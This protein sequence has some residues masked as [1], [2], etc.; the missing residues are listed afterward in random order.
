MQVKFAL[1]GAMLAP[2]LLLTGCGMNPT[3]SI[4]SNAMSAAVSGRA[5]GGQN[6]VVGATI[7]VVA[8]GTSGYGSTGSILAST[9]T[10]SLGNFSFAPGA[11][12]CPQAD[13]PVY[14]TGVGGDS[15][16]GVNP[17]AVLAAGL[18]TCTNAKSSF[19][20]INEV[21]TAA[22]AFSLSHFFSPTI[23]GSNAANDWFGGPSI[24]VGGAT[25]YSKG[26]TMG[27]S[28][29]IPA[30]VSNAV[31]APN[32]PS[33]G[34]VVEAAKIN[35]IANSLAACVNSGG[36]TSTSDTS[37]PCGML[38][39]YTTPPGSSTRPSD[40]LQAAVQM[41]LFPYQNVSQI[42]NLVTP[43]APFSGLSS[44]PS[45]W[46]I[47]VSY[48]TASLGL[49][50]DTGTISTLDIDQDGKVWVPSNAAGSAG[51]AYFDPA[52]RTFNG[53]FNTTGL[54]HPQQVA[55]DGNS[56][57]WYN[58]S[59][60]TA[61]SGYL[62]TSPAST[63][64]LTMANTISDSVTIGDDNRIN[65]GIDN[66][67]VYGVANVSVD[68]SS[69]T[70]ESSVSFPYPV[71]SM[72]GDAVG[73]E[74]VTV[75]DFIIRQMQSWYVDP[76]GLTT[77]VVNTGA[78]SGQVLFTGNDFVSVHGHSTRVGSLYDGLCIY[79]QKTCYPFANTLNN[80]PT[81]IAIDGAANLWVTEGGDSAILHIPVTNPSAGNAT[82][83]LNTSAAIP[84][85]EYFHGSVQGGTMVKP[86]GIGIDAVGNVWVSN[87]GCNTID[88]TPGSFTLTEIIGVAAPTIT[89]VSATITGTNNLVGTE[90]TF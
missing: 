46:T 39:T 47:G 10:D 69:Y 78:L 1:F 80:A 40:T 26:L 48:T 28:H 81:G 2:A 83:Y 20:I 5:F 90:P 44:A 58:D 66:G 73:G 41:A 51:A 55:I 37:T 38:F 72:S 53:P 13:T 19:V 54:V 8:M 27:N 88:C 75:G 63:H 77:D 9:T 43:Q 87:A 18:G 84:Y 17:S 33:S 71:I 67:S 52:S 65:V 61:I 86:Y 45:D 42:Y 11:Y 32:Q 59:G 68:R 79:T 34:Y 64:S 49:A 85:N 23:G 24:T 36:A 6:P 82:A 7:S 50:V 15:G 21:T 60:N 4:S 76:N 22:L 70:L 56:Y 3:T 35:S 57:V 14:I 12:S 25:Q 89:P 16:S 29:T 30:I 31:G 62:S 74:A